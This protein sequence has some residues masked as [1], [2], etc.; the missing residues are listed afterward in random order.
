MFEVAL[1]VIVDDERRETYLELWP[2]S[3]VAEVNGV[4]S[5]LDYVVDQGE[6]RRQRV[7]WGEE[8][9]VSVLNDHLVKVVERRAIFCTT[10]IMTLFN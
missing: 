8:R 1:Y 9:D 3:G 4:D 2:P 6:Q 7:G 5:D 10:A